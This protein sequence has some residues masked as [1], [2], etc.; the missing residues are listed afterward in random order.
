MPYL[1][2][3]AID[4]TLTFQWPIKSTPRF[5]TITQMPASGRGPVHIPLYQFPL[6][7]FDWV[8]SYIPGD[9]TGVNTT[10][11]TLINFFI[12]VQGSGQAFLFLHPYDHTVDQA[13]GAIGT[14]DG[15]T[16]QFTMVRQFIAGGTD[17]LIQNF[18]NP[19][20]IYVNG[21]LQSSSIYTIDQ[22]GTLTFNAG[23][24]PGN[25]LAITWAGQFYFLCRF[26]KDSF[27]EMEETLYQVWQ[28]KAFKFTSELN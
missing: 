18:V 15:S 9:A 27:E 2:C 1:I 26:E 10:Y 25:G 19:P 11:Q 21:V 28:I 5:N 20:S 3:P 13:H 6:W 7:D 14:G 17:D 12:G 8:L 22:Y 4:S 24:A 16:L 23:H